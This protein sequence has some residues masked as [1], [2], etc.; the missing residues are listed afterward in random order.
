MSNQY[1]VQI[2]PNYDHN[3]IPAIQPYLAYNDEY[4][5]EPLSFDEKEQ[6][7]HYAEDLRASQIDHE[8]GCYHT[9]HG[10]VG[11]PAIE[12]VD[13][14]SPAWAPPPDEYAYDGFKPV[15]KSDIPPNI[16]AALRRLNAEMEEPRAAYTPYKADMVAGDGKIWRIA[17]RVDPCAEQLYADDL[18]M[19]NWDDAGFYV[20]DAAGDDDA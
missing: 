2:T 7:E 18:S 15:A 8:T 16:L 19:I 4:S 9:S 11:P 10:E 13:G 14:V 5:R 1:F 6:A 12:V 20:A 17:W 3:H